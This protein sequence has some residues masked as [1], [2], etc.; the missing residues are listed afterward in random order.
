MLDKY[1]GY[2]HFFNAKQGELSY[3]SFEIEKN[4]PLDNVELKVQE[5][6]ENCEKKN[7]KIV[8]IWDE[9]FPELLKNITSPPLL[10]FVR[11]NLP[12]RDLNLISIVGTRHNTMY[13]KLITEKFVEY[14]VNNNIGIVSGLA[15]GIDT[16]SHRKVCEMKGKTFAIVAHGVDMI[17]SAFSEKIASRIVEN[18][19]GIISEYPCGTPAQIGYF[20]VRNRIISGFSQATLIIESGIKSGTL[21]TAKF[22]FDQNREVY[23]I[24]GNINSEKS[25][26]CN[27]LI[28]NNQSILCTSPEQILIDFG[29]KLKELPLANEAI[30]LENA[31]ELKL[32]KILDHEPKQVDIIADMADLEIPQVLVTLLNLEFKGLIKQLPGKNFIKV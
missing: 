24:P 29:W 5:L 12:D 30:Q 28:K 26:G 2:E 32:Y 27:E 21:I 18:G 10:L 20:P 17:S 15:N 31:N 11:G 25:K 3:N 7:I 19:G 13:G 6:L 4:E 1:Q 14:F 22:A 16:I 23:A 8:T 9:N